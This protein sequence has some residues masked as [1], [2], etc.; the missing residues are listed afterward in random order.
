MPFLISLR[1]ERANP[2]FVGHN[3]F[4]KV[5]HWECSKMG[6]SVV[7]AY[8]VALAHFDCKTVAVCLSIHHHHFSHCRFSVM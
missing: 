7:F 1:M 6:E 5:V 4:D 3:D 8:G 2:P